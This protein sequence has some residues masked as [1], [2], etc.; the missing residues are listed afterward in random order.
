MSIKGEYKPL[1][2]LEAAMRD[3]PAGGYRSADQHQICCPACG[4]DQYDANWV[5]VGVGERQVTP[6]HCSDCDYTEED[7]V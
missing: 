3:A 4:S 1:D 2:A 5:D 6:Y 7:F